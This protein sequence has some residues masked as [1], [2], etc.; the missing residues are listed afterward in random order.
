MSLVVETGS[1]SAS[2][3]AY[4]SEA[5]ADTYIAA[6]TSSTTWAGSTTVV[7]E[8]AI[9][10]AT[11]YLDGYYVWRGLAANEDQALVWPRINAVDDDNFT[12]SSTS[13]PIEVVNACAELAERAIGEILEGDLSA[14]GGIQSRK[15]VKVGPIEQDISFVG[16]S[17]RLQAQYPKVDGM[18]KGLVEGIGRGVSSFER[19]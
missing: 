10:N 2:S 6:F 7:K 13:I 15:A 3:D 14:A 1:G 8:L 18:L 4:I 17:F 11:Q 9:R 19:S 5:D 16:G 12:R